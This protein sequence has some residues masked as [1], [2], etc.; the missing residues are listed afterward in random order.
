LGQTFFFNFVIAL[1]RDSCLFLV[2]KTNYFQADLIF[3]CSWFWCWLEKHLTSMLYVNLCK[4]CEISCATSGE[5]PLCK[6]GEY[7]VIG[8]ERASER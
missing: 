2:V 3:L 6:G 1:Q 4:S 8:G 7:G 5:K